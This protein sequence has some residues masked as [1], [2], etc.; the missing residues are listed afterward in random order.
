[1]SWKNKGG[2]RKRA[3]DDEEDDNGGNE[4]KIEVCRKRFSSLILI[5]RFLIIYLL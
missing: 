1:M 3:D 4:V 5:T 2:A